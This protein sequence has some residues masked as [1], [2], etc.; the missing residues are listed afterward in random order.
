M[1]ERLESVMCP[2]D[3]R[4]L[5]AELCYVLITELLRLSTSDSSFLKDSLSLSA[6]AIYFS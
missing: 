6:P 3:S 1:N 2:G 5:A 4:R